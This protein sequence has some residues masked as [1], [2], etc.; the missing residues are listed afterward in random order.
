MDKNKLNMNDL[1]QVSGGATPKSGTKERKRDKRRDAN[2]KRSAPDL[3]ECPQ[4]HQL[5][6]PHRVCK[7]C[8]CYDGQGNLNVD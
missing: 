8:G 2:W 6:L 3:V 1:A 7:N 5:K 4:C